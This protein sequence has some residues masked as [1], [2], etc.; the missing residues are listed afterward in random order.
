VI[1]EFGWIMPI[2]L[3]AFLLVVG[4]DPHRFLTPIIVME[5][6]S[7]SAYAWEMHVRWRDRDGAR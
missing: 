2:V 5:A 3:Y 4:V 6:I 1:V 7:L